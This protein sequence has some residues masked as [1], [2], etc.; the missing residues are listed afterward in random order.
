MRFEMQSEVDRLAA[1]LQQSVLIEDIDQYPV[2]WST[3]GEVDAV[4]EKTV[5]YR[6]VS[7]E[8][9]KVIDTFGIANSQVPVRTPEIAELG[10][11]ARWCMPIRSR[12]NLLGFLW[13]LDRDGTVTEE[14]TA[15]IVVCAGRAADALAASKSAS[16]DV[17][18]ERQRLLQQLLAGPDVDPAKKLMNLESL[19][20]DTMIQVVYP[21]QRSDWILEAGFGLRIASARAESAA[22]GE[23][24][25]LVRLAE[26]FKRAAA[27][28][29]VVDIGGRLEYPTWDHLGSW[30]LVVEA[31]VS[32]Q[33]TDVHAGVS[34]LLEAEREELRNT[35]FVLCEH[36][37]DISS[38]A[39]ALHT[40]RTTLYY[41]LDRIQ[42]LTGVDLRKGA[43]RTDLH[44]ALRLAAFRQMSN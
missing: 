8:T 23:P 3:V 39:E 16:S 42:A 4:R 43:D 7:I 33:P 30:R 21:A 35:A 18:Q 29:R 15:E 9:A 25:P 1:S 10:M 13:V 17:R 28:V 32:L 6:N 31:P 11:W 22:S 38:A 34:H 5:L 41:R 36:G 27:T 24:L 14:Q 37:G 20:I 40:H 26:A 2:W 12:G 44:F 19:P